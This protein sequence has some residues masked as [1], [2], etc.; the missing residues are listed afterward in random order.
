MSSPDELYEKIYLARHQNSLENAYRN[1]G[2]ILSN[3]TESHTTNSLTES[4]KS[5]QQEMQALEKMRES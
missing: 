3:Y 1:L 4:G 2:S 5:N